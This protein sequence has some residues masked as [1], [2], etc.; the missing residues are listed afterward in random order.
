MF[1][2]VSILHDTRIV[3]IW[4][5]V[6][7]GLLFSIVDIG[8]FALGLLFLWYHCYSVAAFRSYIL[9]LVFCSCTLMCLCED[10]FVF[11]IKE[12]GFSIKYEKL[13]GVISENIVPLPFSLFSSWDLHKLYINFVNSILHI[14]LLL[15]HM[16]HNSCFS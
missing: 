10:L 5:I 3:L 13:L 16:S 2:W 6:F 4:K 11:C 8:K 7:R 15:F 1:F 9:S 12:S 14:F